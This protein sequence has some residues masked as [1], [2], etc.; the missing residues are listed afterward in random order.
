MA[1]KCV[2]MTA[3]RVTVEDHSGDFVRTVP[4]TPRRV[5]WELEKDARVGDCVLIA[6]ELVA[7]IVEM[8]SRDP[9]P[10]DIHVRGWD[11]RYLLGVIEAFGAGSLHIDTSVWWPVRAPSPDGDAVAVSR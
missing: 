7:D 10:A 11:G 2:T 5:R 3:T 4:V 8:Q 9:L 1:S 6:P